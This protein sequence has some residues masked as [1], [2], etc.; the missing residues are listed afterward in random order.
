MA[1]GTPSPT[2]T[3]VSLRVPPIDYTSRDFEAI[4]Q[5]M[6]RSIPFFAPEWT[7][8]NLS[9]FGIVLQRLTAFVADVL[10]FY[11]DRIGNEAFLP[12]AITRRSVGNL[13]QLINYELR[14]AVPASVD[15]RFTIPEPL[16]GDLLIP[17]GTQ[18]QTTADTV[19]RPIIF[20]TSQ[21]A[22]LLANTIEIEFVPAVQGQSVD[23]TVGLSE[24]V[25][26]QRFDL[27]RTP[28]IDGTIELFID[29][30]AGE[31]LWTEVDSFIAS[32]PDSKHFTTSRNEETGVVSVFF[33]DN[34]QGKIP[35]PGAPIRA[36][37]RIGGGES[38]NV[39]EN[40]I[41]VVNDTVTFNGSA[42]SL[43]V[44]NPLQASG[45]E[46][47]Q[48]IDTAK[49]EGPNSLLALNRAVSLNDYKILSEGFPGVAKA[50]AEVV[51]IFSQ[52]GS[53]CCC[54]VRV[55]I[56]PTGGGPPSTQL[57]DDLEAFLDERKMAGTCLEIA[58]PDF[59]Q[60]DITGVVTVANNFD[61]DSVASETLARIDQF[62]GDD[63][64]F[65]QFG[66][67]IF[68]SDVFAL[69]DTT[70]G[71]DNVEISKLSC[72]PVVTKEVGLADCAFSEVEVGEE[73]VEET[74]TVTF[75]SDTAFNVRGTVSGFQAVTGSVGVP[76]SSDGGEVSFTVTCDGGAPAAGDRAVFDTCPRFASVPMPASSI[77]Q[78]GTIDLT[79]V[80]G[81]VPQRECP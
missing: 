15:L 55:T 48:S 49:V 1:N 10:H 58:D 43:S 65:V 73:A 45:G 20:E 76:Y 25:P 68:M 42:V 19:E 28:V 6:V 75:T 9:D 51:G 24:G 57:K 21:D 70:T 52:G 7:D 22:V 44:T 71:V 79:F 62:F 72:K 4:S 13:L 69:I 54:G 40:T 38:G 3:Q 47:E 11:V 8:H 12:T 66:R 63:S 32:D 37:Y 78:K 5:D 27:E 53:A 18:V 67:P 39:P 29:E 26:R 30:G 14:S 16:T 81:N 74:W 35:D 2:F 60:V 36:E 59:R 31:S 33:G 64:D 46:D 41:T 56:A 61:V 17:A 23:E 50:S 34:A 77:P 80:G